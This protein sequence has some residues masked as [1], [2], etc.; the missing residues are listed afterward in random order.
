MWVVKL[1]L[2]AKD[3]FLGSLALKH[4]LSM[5]GYPLSYYKD[6]GSLYVIATGFIFGSDKKKQEFVRDLKNQKQFVKIEGDGD[7]FVVVI[8]QPLESEL[9]YDPRIIRPSPVVI[10]KEGYHIWDLASFDRKILERVVKF[11]EEKLGAQILQFK[12]EKLSNI[13][14]IKILPNLTKKQKRA[15][16]LA[17]NNGYYEYPKKIK[18]EELAEKLHI[19]S[20]PY[21]AH[22]KKAEGK[23]IPHIYREL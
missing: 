22:L 3:Q 11:S 9:F 4:G 15:L 7:F 19:S 10:N 16:E 18:M 8:K 17:I 20:S 1:K 5:S 12:Q 14:I 6:K 2:D 13:S 21:Q 23:I